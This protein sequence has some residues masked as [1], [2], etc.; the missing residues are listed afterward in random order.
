MSNSNRDLGNWGEQLAGDFLEKRG[1]I[2]LERNFQKRGGEIDIIARENNTLHFVEV[3]TRK[4]ANIQRFGLPEEAVNPAKQKKI[5][6][7]ALIYLS[8]KGSSENINWQF[9]VVA[10]VYSKDTQRAKIVLIEN[11]FEGGEIVD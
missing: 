11:A 1:C 2:I 9:D 3:K 7:T 4:S 5:I 6:K 10:I 8:E